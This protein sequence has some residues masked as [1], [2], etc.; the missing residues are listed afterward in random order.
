MCLRSHL[1]VLRRL[2]SSGLTANYKL[3]YYYLNVCLILDAVQAP[4]SVGSTARQALEMHPGSPSRSQ[5]RYLFLAMSG[6]C[7]A[8]PIGSRMTSRGYERGEGNDVGGMP[9]ASWPDGQGPNINSPL[10]WAD[11]HYLFTFLHRSG[12]S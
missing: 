9:W 6:N 2:D 3:H 12:I 10:L 1:T 4:P 11:L 5:F 8:V 7:P